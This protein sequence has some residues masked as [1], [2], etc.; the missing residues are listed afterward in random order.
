MMMVNSPS[1]GG[2]AVTCRNSVG[3]TKVKNKVY[4]INTTNRFRPRRSFSAVMKESVQWCRFIT[5]TARSMPG[6]ST[7]VPRAFTVTATRKTLIECTVIV[8]IVEAVGN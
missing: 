7:A 5:Y 1:N 3:V 4:F 2:V 6:P 8:R